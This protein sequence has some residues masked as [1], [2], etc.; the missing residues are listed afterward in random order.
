MRCFRTASL[1]IV[2]ALTLATEGLA[3]EKA[4]YWEV[5]DGGG[6]GIQWWTNRPLPGGGHLTSTFPMFGIADPDPFDFTYQPDPG[7]PFAGFATD[8]GTVTESDVVLDGATTLTTDFVD[9]RMSLL[10]PPA[11]IPNLLEAGGV[12][13]VDMAG[14]RLLL[15]QGTYSYI[16]TDLSGTVLGAGSVDFGASPL[17][18]EIA[19][20]TATFSTSLVGELDMH[21]KS[22]M[23]PGY[24]G[25]ENA[26]LT[27]EMTY[28]AVAVPE[29][30]TV[31]LAAAAMACLMAFGF[32]ARRFRS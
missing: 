14:H 6:L 26:M 29:P 12:A 2:C 8:L 30:S 1:A 23:S 18:L 17:V 20:G 11:A 21:I 5:I 10:Q 16:E 19:E 15:D 13:T 24:F 4:N 32:A 28:H 22:A 3:I 27:F 7:I 31:S 9:V 25:A